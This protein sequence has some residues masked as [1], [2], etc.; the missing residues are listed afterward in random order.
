MIKKFKKIARLLKRYGFILF[1]KNKIN[2][3]RWHFPNAYINNNISLKYEYRNQISIGDYSVIS[4]FVTITIANDPNNNLDNSKLIIGSHTYI[5]EF[6]NIRAGG[7]FI[8]I[9]NNCSISQHITIVA[10]NHAYEK[11]KLIKE[12]CWSTDN[13]FVIIED[14]VWIGANSVVLPGVSIGRGAVI[15]AGS[16][17]TKDIPAY[18]IAVG[19]PSKV[20][21]YRK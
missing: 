1:L 10:S 12:Q 14:D 18:A 21:K 5:G 17:V 3:L 13:N 9:G 16:V 8:R 19:N 4:D 2:Q 7:G 6:N 20:I 15:G 11:D